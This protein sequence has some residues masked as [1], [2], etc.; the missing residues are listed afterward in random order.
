MGLQEDGD[1]SHS[2]SVNLEERPRED[3]EKSAIYEPGRTLT[4]NQISQYLD[5]GLGA[6]RTMRNKFTLF[7]TAQF[8]V[9][10]CGSPS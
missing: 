3:S 6:P 9:F 4:R 8:V 1:C 7:K 2:L 5:L 10:C